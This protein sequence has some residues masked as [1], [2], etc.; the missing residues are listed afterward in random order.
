[1]TEDERRAWAY[2]CRVAEAPN[3]RIAVLVQ[4]VGVVEAAERVR[5]RDL[6][7]AKLLAAT[8]ARHGVDCAREDL[9]VLDRLGG[10]LVTPA[11]DEWP[12]MAFSSFDGV[13]TTTRPQGYAPLAL[14]VLGPS[15]LAEIPY[16]AAALVGTRAASD[17][18]EYAAA[19]L[20]AGLVE[21]EVAV[22]SGGA[23]GID[24]AAHRAVLS[25]DGATVAVVA[26]GVDVP[27]PSGHSALL[28]R[29]ARHGLVVSEYPPGSRPCRRHFLARN[30]LIAALSGATVVVEAGIRSG[31][32]NTAAWAKAL[33][34]N[35]CAVPGPITSASSVGCHELLKNDA[36][37][38][39]VTRAEEIV[40]LVGDYGE[41]A[42]EQPR[43]RTAVDG[44]SAD[45]LAVYEALP[46]RGTRAVDQIAVAAGMPETAVIGQLTMLDIRGLVTQQDGEWKVRRPGNPPTP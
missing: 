45:E 8:E 23:Y 34:R 25:C 7:D 27:Y 42:A 5:R 14:W 40:E 12:V 24:G 26:S 41:F 1:M 36:T 37:T 10:R 46:G 28:H 4:T 11:D 44:L 6:P 9:A 20:A 13:D 16:R 38:H 17:Y 3:P 22:V 43:P 15:S 18:G 29:V 30:R 32:A 19:D 39:L 2:L 35:V 33:G 21:R 31:A